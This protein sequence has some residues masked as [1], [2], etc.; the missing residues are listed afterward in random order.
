VRQ[1]P[2]KGELPPPEGRSFQLHGR[3]PLQQRAFEV[4]RCLHWLH[5]RSS[6]AACPKT[7]TVA[8]A[9]ASDCSV[10]PY[11]P[12]LKGRGYKAQRIKAADNTAALI[13]FE[14]DFCKSLYAQ[15]ASRWRIG[16]FKRIQRVRAR[17]RDDDTRVKFVNMAIHHGNYLAYGIASLVLWILGIPGNMLVSHGHSRAGGLVYDLAD[18]YKDAFVLPMAFAM[19]A[20]A[21]TA[22]PFNENLY[23]AR[24][25]SAFDGGGRNDSRVIGIAV[26]AMKD[27]IRSAGSDVSDD[28]AGDAL[29]SSGSAPGGDQ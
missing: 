29:R 18:S 15:I 12:S 10:A 5:P 3:L 1:V 17:D 7:N 2:E 26:Q 9:T 28:D 21:D 4:L 27:A 11:I 6:G 19:A 24:V 25:L 23:R 14:G 20:K 8:E 16:S 13:G 22:K